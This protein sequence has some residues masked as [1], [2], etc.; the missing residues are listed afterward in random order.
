MSRRLDLTVLLVITSHTTRN[1][2]GFGLLFPL[3]F[4][5][6]LFF[7]SLAGTMMMSDS[8]S[9]GLYPSHWVG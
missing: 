8:R 9:I 1:N 5:R 4:T 2:S 3:T 7:S 6:D